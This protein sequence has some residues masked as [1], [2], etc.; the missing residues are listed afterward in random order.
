M[1][2]DVDGVTTAEVYQE[3]KQEGNNGVEQ[4]DGNKMTLYNFVKSMWP[5]CLQVLKKSDVCTIYYRNGK[6]YNEV[7]V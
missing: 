4:S 6:N 7:I 2:G 1:L 3:I 5:Q